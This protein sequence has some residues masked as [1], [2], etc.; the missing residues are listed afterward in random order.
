LKFAITALN[1][2]LVV[3]K[4]VAAGA[5][6]AYLT[7]AAATGSATAAQTLAELT[8]KRSTAAL[9]AYKIAMVA[10]R[11]VTI[12]ATVAQYA[13]NLALT[14]NPIGLVIAAVAA[15]A[16][17]FV[18]AYKKIK[19]FRDLMDSIFQK[20]KDVVK[21]VGNSPIGKAIG[22]LF[23]GFKAAGGPVRQ[24]RSYVVGE[25][26]PELFTASTSGAISPSGSF[27]GGG[28]VNITINGAIDPEGV[29]RQ[30]ENLFQNS[31]RRTGAINLI[32]A[33]L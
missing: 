5:K 13:L 3:T 16:I 1:T 31:A 18:I 9:I 29:R 20:I 22:G 27:G 25:A 8:Y 26:G 6:L 28:G 19:P 33:T 15:L 32:G 2:I 7:L 30:L 17:A 23:D 10:Q 11:A 4:F 24:G 14:L 21:L 12:A